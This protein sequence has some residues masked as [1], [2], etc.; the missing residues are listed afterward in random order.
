MK[1]GSALTVII[2]VFNDKYCDLYFFTPEQKKLCSNLMSVNT[3][4]M[5]AK[6]LMS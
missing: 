1:D 2:S 4:N 5:F 3:F 6:N